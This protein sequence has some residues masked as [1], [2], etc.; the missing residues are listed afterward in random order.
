MLRA[1]VHCPFNHTNPFRALSNLHYGHAAM[2]VIMATCGVPSHEMRL[3]STFLCG[4][5]HTQ[6][7]LVRVR[8]QHGYVP[9]EILRFRSPKHSHVASWP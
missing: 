4:F 6:N 3:E 8:L 1:L 5:M 2:K 9:P 7:V